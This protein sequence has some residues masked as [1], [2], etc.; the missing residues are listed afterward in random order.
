MSNPKTLGDLK[1]KLMAEIPGLDGAEAQR[2][3]NVAYI[4]EAMR[5]SWPHLIRSFVLQTEAPYADG[6]LL[7]TNGLT[8]V[9]LTDGTWS[10]SWTTAPSMRRIAIQG[11]FEPYGITITSPTTGTLADPWI[12]ETQT[13]ATYSLWRDTYPLPVDCGFAKLMALYDPLLRFRLANKTQSIFFRDRAYNPQLVDIPAEIALMNHTSEV[14]PRPQFS[15]YPAPDSVRAYQGFYFG[16]PSFMT[17]DTQYPDW[18]YEY[19]DLI[20]LSAVIEHYSTARFHSPKYL[21]L[22][23]PTYAD[24]YSLAVKNLDGDSTLDIIIEDISTGRVPWQASNAHWTPGAI[25]LGFVGA[26]MTSS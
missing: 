26:G 20:W 14:P 25:A 15:M 8:A 13:A 17:A 23:K 21:N 3:I 2:R 10:T 7:V 1:R 16:R 6:T 22:F 4:N 18:P 12:G 24:L 5:H 19:Q 9:T 11:R